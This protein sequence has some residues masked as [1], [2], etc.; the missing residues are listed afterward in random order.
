MSSR[1]TAQYARYALGGIRLINGVLG[2]VTPE[3]LIGRIDPG[4]S[5]NPAAVYAFR[6][7]GVRTVLLGAELLTSHGARQREIVREGVLI[8]ASDTVTSVLLGA[9]GLLPR[10]TVVM[11][12]LISA[13]NTVLALVALERK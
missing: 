5:P 11:L 4:S 7:F 6:L 1:R 10:R 12:V 8:H 2:W 9:R 3:R 13:T